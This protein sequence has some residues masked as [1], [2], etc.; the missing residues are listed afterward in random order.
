MIHFIH[1][2]IPTSHSVKRN[3]LVRKKEVVSFRL[4]KE[5]FVHY[6]GLP[7]K[8]AEKS[9]NICQMWTISFRKIWNFLLLRLFNKGLN[10]RISKGAIPSEY[11]ANWYGVEHSNYVVVIFVCFSSQV[12]QCVIMMV[13][14]PFILCIFIYVCTFFLNWCLYLVQRWAEFVLKIDCLPA[15]LGGA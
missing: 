12:W 9:K 11:G 3:T 4:S 10:K 2:I 5:Y 7:R 14:K 1:F 15:Y 13:N 8:V 6:A